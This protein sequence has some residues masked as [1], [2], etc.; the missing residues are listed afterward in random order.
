MNLGNLKGVTYDVGMWFYPYIKFLFMDYL[1]LLILFLGLGFS[2][3]MLERYF[4][5]MQ[6]AGL[7]RKALINYQ[8]NFRRNNDNQSPRYGL[9]ANLDN[10]TKKVTMIR[11]L[12]R[13]GFVLCG[14]LFL[15]VFGFMAIG[16]SM[17]SLAEWLT[18]K[19]GYITRGT[20]YF[21]DARNLY[22]IIWV[23]VGVVAGFLLA[24]FFYFLFMRDAIAKKDARYNSE[25]VNSRKKT[26]HRSG[27]MSDARTLAFKQSIDFDP[28]AY[29]N[30]AKAKNSVFLGVNDNN[31][32]I[33]IPRDIWKKSNVQIMGAVGSG[34]GVL[35]CCALS[36]CVRNFN[37]CVIWFD[38]KNDEFAQHVLKAQTPN[39]TLIDL[40]QGKPAQLN[41]F[42]SIS[43]Y[44]LSELLTAGFSLGRKGDIAD[45]YRD[46]DRTA[47]RYLSN[48]FPNGTN[49]H[50]LIQA[51]HALPKEIKNAAKGFLTLLDELGTL[52]ALKTDTG[53]NLKDIILN[54][55]CLYVIG[56]LRDEAVIMLQ[57]MLFVRCIQIIEARDRLQET[58]HVNILLDEF[59]YLLSKSSL[60]ALGTVR[61]KNCNILLTHQSLGDFGQCGA[62][63][64]PD[65]V[66]T[67]VIDNT[68]IKWIYRMKDFEA[69]K[70]ASQQTGQ[71]LVDNER[72][73]V[74][75]DIGNIEL[76]DHES[77]LFKSERAL[78]DTNTLQHLP[79]GCAVFIGHGLARLSYSRPIRVEKT[80][81]RLQEFPV[82]PPLIPYIMQ[83]DTSTLPLGSVTK[84]QTANKDND[85]W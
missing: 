52:S 33:F 46:N 25:V 60:E 36:Q 7:T 63:M 61:D 82:L 45:H 17:A 48:Q 43:S 64:Q 21:L 18:L 67:T 10:P 13:G 35:A 28:L 58:T 41:L 55:G 44:E 42:K 84:P 75:T 50:A 54:G 15:A 56:S 32:A 83:D 68:P 19:K 16:V 78:I 14:W 49:I 57:K 39:F 8:D 1:W 74:S 12:H 53:I 31:E 76:V 38:P 66:K 9:L 4:Q 6:Y 71:I 11:Y 24:R 85:E 5:H 40:R 80:T 3:G 22:G 51:A 23:L 72:C 37:D 20:Y 77:T 79:D 69:A 26:A 73:K 27:D 70:W 81:I 62:D 34:K 30:E 65:A 29:F 59:K 47:V 2:F